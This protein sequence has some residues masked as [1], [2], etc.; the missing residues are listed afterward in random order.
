M[1]DFTKNPRM[2]VGR[3]DLEPGCEQWVWQVS[4]HMQMYAKR[5][6]TCS[7]DLI[8]EM[9][10]ALPQKPW[11]VFPPNN[12]VKSPDKY[13][14]VLLD[15]SWGE[16]KQAVI[17]VNPKH[18][19]VLD[20]LE[21]E[22]LAVKA[23]ETPAVAKHGEI[24]RG[25]TTPDRVAANK[26]GNSKV[27]TNSSTYRLSKLK[28]DAPEIA[29]RV[30]AGE[31]KNVAEAERAAGIK[32]PKR[33]TKSPAYLLAYCTERLGADSVEEALIELAR[34]AGFELVRIGDDPGQAA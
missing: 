3:E 7:D 24:G 12:P 11:N 19:D 23:I 18:R 4:C 32:P 5:L 1:F 20:E 2:F 30:E 14:A 33:D 6:D 26:N 31:F 10:E 25:R 16:I 13:F 17:L 21:K 34:A 27:G 28:R 22:C 15:K 8:K 9:R 29:K